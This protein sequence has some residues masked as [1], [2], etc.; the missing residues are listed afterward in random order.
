M[1][2][3]HPINTHLSVRVMPGKLHS[4]YPYQ[5]MPYVMQ[6]K[7]GMALDKYGN[8]VSRRDPKAHIPIEEF[9]YRE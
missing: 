3:V 1:E 2:Y 9:I 5:Q 4:P 7:N 8:M 6:M